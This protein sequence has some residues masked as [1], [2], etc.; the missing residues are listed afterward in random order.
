MIDSRNYNG[1]KIKQGVKIP[2][3]NRL[4][5]NSIIDYH[6][7]V[8]QNKMSAHTWIFKKIS[9]NMYEW[10]NCVRVEIGVIRTSMRVGRRAVIARGHCIRV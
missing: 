6:H 4:L 8:V 10:T 1:I 2:T 3:I 7:C 5:H 9:P